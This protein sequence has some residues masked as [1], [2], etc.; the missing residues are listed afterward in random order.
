[1]WAPTYDTNPNPLL[2]LES[3]M[4]AH[5]LN[6]QAPRR[7]IDIACGTGRGMRQFGTSGASAFGIDASWEMLAEARKHSGLRGRLAMAQAGSLP[8]RD[9]AADL[10]LCSFAAGYISDFRTVLAEMRRVCVPGAH[11]IVS[12]LHPRG[13]AAGWSRSFRSGAAVYQIE[14]FIHP[15]VQIRAAAA[16][17]GLQLETQVDAYFGEPERAI[18][19]R[20]G[21]S[22]AIPMV[23]AVPAVW[24]GVWTKP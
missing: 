11:V 14:H 18:F 12:E 7:I 13:I 9:G 2:A 1:M 19:E 23:S 3:R 16:A 24:I 8:F 5:L 10:V 21:K 22:D 15:I 20:A 4:L 17:T 6:S